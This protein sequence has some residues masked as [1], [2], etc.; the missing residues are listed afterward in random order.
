MHTSHQQSPQA[1]ERFGSG[2]LHTLTMI[3]AHFCSPCP[4]P[5]FCESLSICDAPSRGVCKVIQREFWRLK[6]I[7]YGS[8]AVLP[9]PGV[10]VLAPEC[11]GVACL[12]ST[13][14]PVMSC[15]FPFARTLSTALS[16][17][18]VMKLQRIGTKFSHRAVYAYLLHHYFKIGEEII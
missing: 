12:T 7:R 5:S 11:R 6:L 15:I 17:S 14:F 18:K 16:S 3:V 13:R 2:M 10:R 4:L 9:P 8:A 1:H